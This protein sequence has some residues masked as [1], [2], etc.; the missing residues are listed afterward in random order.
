MWTEDEPDGFPILRLAR[1][2]EERAG[3]DDLVEIITPIDSHG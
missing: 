2:F 3:F 1:T